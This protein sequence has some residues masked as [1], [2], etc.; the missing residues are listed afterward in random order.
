[1]LQAQEDRQ[2]VDKGDQ[3]ACGQRTFI[4]QKQPCGVSIQQG[5]YDAEQDQRP[6]KHT[7]GSSKSQDQTL[8]PQRADTRP[9]EK[10]AGK[11]HHLEDTND[12]GCRLCTECLACAVTST[13]Q[14][15]PCSVSAFAEPQTRLGL[16]ASLLKAH[17]NLSC[18]TACSGTCYK[19]GHL[20]MPGCSASIY[21]GC[22]ACRC[23][24]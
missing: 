4:Q 15:W 7:P 2:P 9:K 6:A 3:Q 20:P 21:H 24:E 5:L 13:V 23:G 14:L 1:M 18:I 17:Y 11:E 16:T 10:K 12:V 8:L 22:I 19:Q